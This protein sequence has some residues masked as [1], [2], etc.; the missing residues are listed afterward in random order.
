LAASSAAFTVMLRSSI[1]FRMSA[2]SAPVVEDSPAARTRKPRGRARVSNGASILPGVDGRS[3]LGRRYRDIAEALISDQGGAANL[4]EAKLQLIWRF[5]AAACLAEQMES[6]LVR[7][8]PID[9]Q[10]HATLCSSLVRLGQRI[11]INRVA[12]D[13]TPTVAQYLEHVVKQDQGE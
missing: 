8:E 6:R 2:D 12:R 4:S 9:L 7:G 13:V 3:A 1:S 11:G 5:A 10:E